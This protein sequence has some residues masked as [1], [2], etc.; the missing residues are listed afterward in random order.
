MTNVQIHQ[1][2]KLKQHA[3]KSDNMLGNNFEL[4]KTKKMQKHLNKMAKKQRERLKNSLEEY[5]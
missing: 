5:L 1:F 3:Y 2:L 4:K